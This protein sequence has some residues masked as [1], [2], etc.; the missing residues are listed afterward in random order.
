MK[1]IFCLANHESLKTPPKKITTGHTHFSKLCLLKH[2]ILV[3]KFSK[4]VT[5][6][7]NESRNIMSPHNESK[8]VNKNDFLHFPAYISEREIKI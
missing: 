1:T 8:L 7:Y 2:V 3:K 6:K 5:F 4:P